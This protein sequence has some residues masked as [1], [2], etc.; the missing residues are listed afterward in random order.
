MER[1]E[2]IL[3]RLVELANDMPGVKTVQRNDVAFSETDVPA[4]VILDGDE[5]A[6]DSAYQRKRGSLTPVIVALSPEVFFLVDDPESKN[7][8]TRLN[9]LYLAFLRKCL[10]DTK[11][12]SLAHDDDIRFNSFGSGFAAGRVMRAEGNLSLTIRYVFY[13]TS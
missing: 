6:D 1:K 3:G 8:G 9:A 7:A 11:L 12:R 10:N 5:E 4:I 2:Q 13:P